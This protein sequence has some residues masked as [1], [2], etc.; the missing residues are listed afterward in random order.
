MITKRQGTNLAIY[1]HYLTVQFFIST[2]KALSFFKTGNILSEYIVAGINRDTLTYTRS[3]N[4]LLQFS[5]YHTNKTCPS[6]LYNNTISLFFW[7]SGEYSFK[8][9]FH[10]FIFRRSIC[11]YIA[12][13]IWKIWVKIYRIL[14]LTPGLFSI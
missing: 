1:I 8:K 2:F 14:T 3:I 4:F 13:G 10:T 12:T 9:A 5:Q 11:H 6:W 7:L